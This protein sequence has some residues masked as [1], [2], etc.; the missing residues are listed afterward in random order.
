MEWKVKLNKRCIS[1]DTEPDVVLAHGAYWTEFLWFKL[2][3]LAKKKIPLN[4]PFHVD[5]TDINVSI[6]YRDEAGLTTRSN[7]LDIS[8]KMIESQLQAWE[9]LPQLSL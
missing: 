9:Q 7:G 5:D 3:K 4:R 2:D 1:K 6:N 8:W